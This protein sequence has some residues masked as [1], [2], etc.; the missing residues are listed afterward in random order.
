MAAKSASSPAPTPHAAPAV[1]ASNHLIASTDGGRV[2]IDH[3]VVAKIV[4]LA[5]V[6][7]PGV[8]ALAAHGAG[9]TIA[10]FATQL[11]GGAKPDYGVHIE[12]GQ[13]E[14]AADIRLVVDYGADIPVIAAGIREVITDRVHRMTGLTLRELNI[15][16][17]DL[18]FGEEPKIEEPSGREL[19]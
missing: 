11:R 1:V 8:H 18:W 17:V 19:K 6:E 13:T 14:F 16:I 10:K 9:E 5:V 2:T 12:I 7:V 15:N 3:S 4:G